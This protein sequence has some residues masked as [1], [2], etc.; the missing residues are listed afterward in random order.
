MRSEDHLLKN[1]FLSQTMNSCLVGDLLLHQQRSN[2]TWAHSSRSDPL[3][4]PCLG[5]SLLQLAGP[6]GVRLQVDRRHI[7]SVG[8][9]PGRDRPPDSA[10]AT[11]DQGSTP[12][13]AQLQI[14]PP[15]AE[16]ALSVARA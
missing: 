1:A 8:N 12:I 9:Q 6:A 10:R 5:E 15:S 3:A 2:V 13:E 16:P 14:V 7:K 4:G 11:G